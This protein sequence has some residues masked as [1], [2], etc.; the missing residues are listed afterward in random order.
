MNIELNGEKITVPFCSCG[1]CILRRNRNGNRNTKYPY[2]KHLSSTYGKAHDP[3]GSGLSAQFFNRS[4]RNGFENSYKEHLTAGLMSTMK[5]DYKPFLV[6]LD[7]KPENQV[8]EQTPFFGRSTYNAN[9]P[10]WGGASSG[11]GPKIKL[12]LISVPFRGNSNYDE[13]FKRF[14]DDTYRFLSP[15]FKQKASL[16]FRGKVLNDS[17]CKESFRPVDRQ[18]VDYV[19]FERPRKTDREKTV[20]IPAEYPKADGFNST[21]GFSFQD[22][23]DKECELSLFLKKSGLKNLEL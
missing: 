21:Y 1:K 7:N 8:L 19:G 10:S 13:N 4:I 20:I 9:Y 18:K 23:V 11:N 14:E 12:P 5:F 6:K 17:N 22:R 3:K 16:E 2:N 15:N